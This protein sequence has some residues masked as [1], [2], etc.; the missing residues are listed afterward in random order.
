[1][2][3]GKKMKIKTIAS[4]AVTLLASTAAMADGLVQS[5][6]LSATTQLSAVSTSPTSVVSAT[7]PLTAQTATLDPVTGN[8]VVSIFTDVAPTVAVTGIGSAQV[9]VIQSATS[10][11]SI[12]VIA[13]GSSLASIPS[14]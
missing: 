10:S 2:I 12:P 9:T 3:K 7:A 4:L 6:S 13:P 1:M 5:V 14:L 11:S 8:P